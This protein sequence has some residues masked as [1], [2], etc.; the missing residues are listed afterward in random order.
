MKLVDTNNHAVTVT[1]DQPLALGE[2]GRG[3]WYEE[4]RVDARRPPAGSDYGYKQFEAGGAHTRR[5]D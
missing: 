2:R 1:V 5:S 4:V 3:R